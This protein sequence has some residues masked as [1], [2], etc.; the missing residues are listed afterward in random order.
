MFHLRN[1]PASGEEVR[2]RLTTSE[3]ER[4]GKRERERESE[5]CKE[6]KR[7]RER[8]RNSERKSKNPGLSMSPLYY[9]AHKKHPPP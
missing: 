8:G 9:L 2:P 7:E 6:I 5:R 3:R 1:G 4:D